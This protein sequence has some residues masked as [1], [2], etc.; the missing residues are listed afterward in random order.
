MYRRDQSPSQSP[1]R[2][3][4]LYRRI[5]GVIALTS[6]T[7]AAWLPLQPLNALQPI[8]EPN[9]IASTQETSLPRRLSGLT[10]NTGEDD[11]LSAITDGTYGYFGTNT[12]PGRVVKVRLSDMTR[13]GSVVLPAGDDV[14]LS[15]TTDGR[16]GYFGTNTSPGRV[17]KV[18]LVTMAWEGSLTLRVGE[19]RLYSAINDGEFGYF[20]TDTSPGRI[21]KVRLSDMTRVGAVELNHGTGVLRSVATD[22]IF[23]YFGS[24]TF[25]GSIS[26][27]Q[28]AEL[29]EEGQLSLD[30]PELADQD[31]WLSPALSDE[32]HAYFGINRITGGPSSAKVSK[33][34]MADLSRVAS[35]TLDPEETIVSSAVTD[36]AYGYFGTSRG[37]DYSREVVVKVRLSDMTRVGSVT[38]GPGETQLR[39]AVTD[40]SFGYFGT[41]SSPG[42]VVKV[43]LD[44]AVSE[45]PGPPTSVAVQPDF[46]KLRISARPQLD[47]GRATTVT[48]TATPNR[49]G[50]PTKSCV[51]ATGPGSCELTG[52]DTSTAYRVSVTAANAA[53]VSTASLALNSVT[54][55]AGSTTPKF[56]DVPNG[57]FF[58]RATSMLRDRGVTTGKG[59]PSTFAPYD[60]VTRAEMATFLHRLMGTPS[61]VP[62]AYKDQA[63]IAPFARTATCWLKAEGI[64]TNDPFNPEAPVTRAQMAAFLYRLSGEPEVAPCSFE[65]QSSIPRFARAGACWLKALNITKSDPYRPLGLVTRGEM[66]AFLYR[67]GAMFG[68]W[69]RQD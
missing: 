7:I 8:D 53:G 61:T 36:G 65:D 22:G 6:L 20:G 56:M 55:G 54:P 57:V 31:G 63:R 29:A 66:A 46:G 11:L 4:R 35:V 26:K 48:A 14:L 1:F 49:L 58:T 41:G 12:K 5:T 24:F 15:G 69:L 68:L 2:R 27:V 39:S 67:T 13:V 51:I 33:I 28:L 45:P 60:A 52:L 18:D 50:V 25:P 59:Q 34:R 10:L 64:T 62:C 17:A 23:G 37:A 40:G 32:S 43:Y 38:L 21:I 42:R 30:A 47:G 19:D 44:A 3:V 9:K 16:Y